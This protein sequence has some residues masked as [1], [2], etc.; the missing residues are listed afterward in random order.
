VASVYDL[1]QRTLSHQE[2]DEVAIFETFVDYGLL[3]EHWRLLFLE[4][5]LEEVTL[6]NN[7]VGPAGVGAGVGLVETKQAMPYKTL[8]S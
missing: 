6:V 8:S 7:L 5:L 3:Q 4:G 2:V 1:V